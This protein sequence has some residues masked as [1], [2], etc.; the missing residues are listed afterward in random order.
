MAFHGAFSAVLAEHTR[1][2][3]VKSVEA[4]KFAENHTGIVK[5]ERL[6]KITG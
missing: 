1:H 6:V 3:V 4:D 2:L 5:T